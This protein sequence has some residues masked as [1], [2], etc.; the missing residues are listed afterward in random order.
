MGGR[1]AYTRGPIHPA[2]PR[3]ILGRQDH[4]KPSARWK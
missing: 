3:A 1:Y 2:E 4:C